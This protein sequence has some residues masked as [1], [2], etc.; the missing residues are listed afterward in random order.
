MR[1][2]PGNIF[3]RR[4]GL[5]VLAAIALFAGVHT[6]AADPVPR[7]KVMAAI[8]KLEAL[9]KEVIAKGE[10]PGL[11]IAIVH[12][13][14]VV[15]LNGFGLRE[16]GKPE[17]VDPDTVFQLASL[18]K[19]ISS[20]VVAAL[21]SDGLVTWDSRVADLL[22]SFQLHDPYPTAQVTVRDLFAHRSGLP[23][24]AGNDLEAIGF[25]RTEILH[26]LRFVPPSSSFR[27]GYSYSNMG[28]TAGAVA[29]AA[30]SGKAWEAIAA[31]KLYDPLGMTATSSRHADFVSRTNRAALHIKPD[32][33][34]QAKL[35]RDADAQAPAGGVSSSARDLA[36][37][38]RLELGK[39]KYEGRQL[40]AEDAIAETHV[41]LM[42]RGDNPVTGSASFYGLGWN[43]EFGRYGLMWGHAGAFSVG[44]RTLV[45]IYPKSDLGLI[46]LSNAFPTGVPEG[47]ADSFADLVFAGNVTRDWITPWNAAYD[48]LFGPA[49]AAV[50]KT[51]SAPPPDKTPA[52]PA[53]AYAGH[54]TND[55]AGAADIAE[56]EGKLT[57]KL[58]P[59]GEHSFALTHFDRDLFLYYPDPE[60]ADV[61][62]AAQFLISPDG[63][64][65]AVTLDSL[66]GSGMGTLLRSAD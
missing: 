32:G 27:A 42:T 64:A 1:S 2:L 23:G 29:A 50:R 65:S 36:Q 45:S 14:E 9:I 15:Y 34:W 48:A 47:I 13:D 66:N 5:T 39:G 62:S 59:K 20:T 58:G 8:P 41:P 16:M 25:D 53:K 38:L 43:V 56:A 46:I 55:Y 24:D 17:T 60:M 35:T 52:L 28:I 10:V 26:R 7:E 44:A 30:P 40:I 4:A 57:L 61:P 37:W 31:E 18:S 54:Y 19:P 6:A 11:S 22:P 51:Y 21:V 63:T 12:Q 49:A 33:T 3:L